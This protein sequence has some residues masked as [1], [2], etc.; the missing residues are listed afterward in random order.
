MSAA[1]ATLSSP[2]PPADAPGSLEWMRHG[3]CAGS[4]TPDLWFP[5]YSD[6]S[7]AAQ[8]K[9]A[10]QTCPVTAA[11]LAY[12]L[13]AGIRHGIWGGA[14]PEERGARRRPGRPAAATPARTHEAQAARE[15]RSRI[16]QAAE[17]G[18]PVAGELLDG[19]RARDRNRKARDAA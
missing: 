3:S 12:A 14:T 11:C 5:D 6:W 18:D 16:R 1:Q 10:C 2:S 17:A 15:R 13:E 8:A 19:E 4:K 7:T 9:A